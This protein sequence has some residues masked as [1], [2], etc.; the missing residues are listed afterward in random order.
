MWVMR[1]LQLRQLQGCMV[2]LLKFRARAEAQNVW[3]QRGIVKLSGLLFTLYF[4]AKPI[5][6]F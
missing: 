6:S 1:D 2:G 3:K 5:F 4:V